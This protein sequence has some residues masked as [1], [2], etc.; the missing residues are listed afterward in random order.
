MDYVL[1]LADIDLDAVPAVGRKAAVLG[2]LRGAGFPVPD[3]FAVTTSALR[4][5]LDGAAAG[6]P[7]HRLPLPDGLADQVASALA[8]LGDTPVAVRSSGVAEDLAGRSFAGMY[9]SY[10]NVTGVDA[11]LEATRRC[12]ASGFS[13]R[14][15][16]YR[17]EPG[18]GPA[19]VAVLVQ[20]M[21]PATAAGVAF[22]V[23]P[24]TG[25]PGEIAVSA[26]GGLGDKLMS[27]ETSAEEWTVRSGIPTRVS[28]GAAVLDAAQVGPIADLVTRVADRLGGPQDMEWAIA[29]GV[30]HVLQARPITGL[31][32]VESIPLT[33]PIPDG[34]WAQAPN[35]N[36]PWVAMQQ[37]TFLPVFDAA[38][39]NIF[40]YTTGGRADA[41]MIR[42]WAYL[43]TRIDSAPD[44]VRGLE[45]AGARVATGEPRAVI[46][47]W[48]GGQK[49]AYAAALRGFR[50][51]GLGRLDEAAFDRH[52]RELLA[53]FADLH[54][55]YFTLA[56]AGIAVLGEFGLA[57]SELLGYD[58]GRAFSMLGEP[59][60][61]HTPAT[62][63]LAD[64][65]RMAAADRQLRA[66]LEDG[67]AGADDLA[68]LNPG[69][70]AAFA[71]YVSEYGHRTMG[72]DITEPTLAE[73]PQ[74]LLTLV[75]AQLDKPDDVDRRRRERTARRDAARAEARAEVE[76][77]APADRERFERALAGADEGAALRDEKVFY[78]VSAWALVR[79]ATQELGRRL[80]A[81]GLVD[82]GDD[83]FHLEL[84]EGLSALSAG[85]DVRAA[86]REARGRHNWALAHPGP[87]FYG[88]FTVPPGIDGMP[89][90]PAAQHVRAMGAW[91]MSLR[92]GPTG[93]S[94]GEG[95]TGLAASAG[96]YTGP[97]RVVRGIGE[98]GKLRRGD[99]LVCPE[100][101]AQWSIVFVMV[102]ALIT[103]QGSLLSH[104]AIIA[105]E[106]GVPAVL[107]TG[108]ATT[109][110]RDGQLVTVD[111]SSGRVTV[112]G[113]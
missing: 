85:K 21:V 68:A 81:A 47:R 90:S 64:L 52:C 23:N 107:A 19:E 3:G 94:D 7:V 24:V 56:G 97:V 83:A 105:R 104:P 29:G 106:Y 72:F 42:G 1:P 96:R 92:G 17:T 28:D 113:G 93:G 6:T 49:R 80:H 16:A 43:T 30:L 73:Y 95:L 44:Q 86:V 36:S 102:G 78:A 20:A 11:V 103:D 101:T 8:R 65:A 12:W 71:R 2:V 112:V 4:D 50:E 34:F 110:L 88:E 45:E 14:V 48:N 33:E 18:E 57:C 15:T 91:S 87:P 9:E 75:T 26:V 74:T 51:T 58:A 55:T 60:G 54:D 27:G 22:S 84:E 99:V 77:L 31:S 37:S 70:A 59:E 10:L 111:G 32:T 100:T 61:D 89:L 109:T 63:G 53:L 82:S 62:T 41:R 79:Y 67:S 108:T 69:F 46:G 25:D 66:R 98:F 38:I 76:R 35:A 39:S 5:A 13:D 40:R